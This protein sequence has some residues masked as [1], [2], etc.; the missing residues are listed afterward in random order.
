LWSG[1]FHI[2]S[3]DGENVLLS[4]T[5]IQRKNNPESKKASHE[6]SFAGLRLTTAWFGS[7]TWKKATGENQVGK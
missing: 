2:V 7:M 1:L 5:T 4:T 6:A 3:A